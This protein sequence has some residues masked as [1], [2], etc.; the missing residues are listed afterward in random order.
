MTPTLY[1]GDRVEAFVAQRVGTLQSQYLRDKPDAVAALAR[2]RRGVGKRVDADMELLGLALAD[3]SIDLLE[4]RH[5]VSDEPTPEEQAAFTA[6]TLYALHQQSRRDVPLHR[7]GYSLGRSARLLA[8]AVG[9]DAVG[10]RFAALGTATTWDESVHHARGLIQQLRQQKIPLDYGR[11]GRD[12]YDLHVGRGHHV[13]MTWGRDF[14]RMKD[15][16]DVSP[17]EPTENTEPAKES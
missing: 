12:L 11:F 16:D 14:H 10:R 3:P 1:P 5:V 2:L 4:G 15:P 7:R 17:A 6:I 9:P 8:R 13:R